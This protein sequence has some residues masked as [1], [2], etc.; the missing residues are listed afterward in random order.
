MRVS[1][2]RCLGLVWPA[3]EAGLAGL[4]E[5]LGREGPCRPRQWG[6]LPPGVV[7]SSSLS[8]LC[9]LGVIPPEGGT[10]RSW[11]LGL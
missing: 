2:V 4:V 8:P 5:L 9:C 7:P 6:H 1:G 10:E 11:I 3:T